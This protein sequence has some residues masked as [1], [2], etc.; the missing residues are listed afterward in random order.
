[1]VVVCIPSNYHWILVRFVCNKMRVSEL[2]VSELGLLRVLQDELFPVHYSDHFY[3]SLLDPAQSHISLLLWSN[4]DQLIGAATARII[5][6]QEAYLS[7]L[8]IRQDYRL[9]GLGHTI[10]KDITHRIWNKGCAKIT[11]HVKADNI[12]A[13]QLYTKHGFK[14]TKHLKEHYYF[15][16]QH[17]DALEM[18]ALSPYVQSKWDYCIIA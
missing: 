8:G 12:Q 10:L 9:Q 4:D 15:Q 18:E 5:N 3:E 11:L 6:T 13:I 16:D 2:N 17:H 7:T 14:V 1:V